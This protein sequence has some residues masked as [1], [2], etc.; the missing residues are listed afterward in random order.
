MKICDIA[1]QKHGTVIESVTGRIAEL[2]KPDAPSPKQAEKGIHSQNLVIED[3]SG[4][5]RC[6]IIHAP[7]HLPPSCRNRVA[8]LR[9]VNGEK[10]KMGLRVNIYEKDGK[11]NFTLVIDRNATISVTEDEPAQQRE[12]TTGDKQTKSSKTHARPTAFDH[13]EYFKS[14]VQRTAEWVLPGLFSGEK[15]AV[16]MNVDQTSLACL[17]IATRI[18]TTVYI[19]V[20]KDN[21]I[22][23]Q[24][25]VQESDPMTEPV[26]PP[27]GEPKQPREEVIREIVGYVITS[28][29]EKKHAEKLEA[30]GVSWSEVYDELAKNLIKEYGQASVDQA[31]DDS[32]A[33]L[34]EDKSVGMNEE[35]FYRALC[36]DYVAFTGLIAQYATDNDEIPV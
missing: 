34:A 20:S 14:L 13:E 11:S 1:L 4:K 5:I 23:V 26:H 10:G 8:T 36:R 33:R 18:A 15:R 2:F 32:R 28:K 29:L 9:S 30:A 35:K 25:P 12:Q 16:G 3:D 19:Q 17:D 7:M 31:H 24:Q 27:S 21:L 22:P 6:Q